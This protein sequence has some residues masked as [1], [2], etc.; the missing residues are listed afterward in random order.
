MTDDRHV[1]CADCDWTGPESA[2]PPLPDDSILERVG[3]GEI[4][5]AGECPE[6]GAVCHYPDNTEA[7]LRRLQGRAQ[8]L[9]DAYGGDIPDW[10]QGEADALLRAI[11]NQPDPAP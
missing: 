7:Q 3:P 8:E 2:C 9:I 11:H 5:P 4:M 1:A 10:L 6:C